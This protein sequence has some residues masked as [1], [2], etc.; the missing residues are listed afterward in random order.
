MDDISCSRGRPAEKRSFPDLSL[1][2]WYSGI[3]KRLFDI[4]FASVLIVLAALPML[5]AAIAI[6]IEGGGKVLFRQIRVGAGLKPFVC[7]K[8]RTMKHDAPHDCA[9]AK[10]EHPERYITRVGAALRRMSI[11]ELPQLF[12]VLRGDMSLVGPRPVIPAECGLVSLRE[13]LGVYSISPGITGLAQVRG[14]DCLSDRRKAA[15]D[16]QYLEHMSFFFDLKLLCC[17]VISVLTCRGIH[18]GR[19]GK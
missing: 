8:F 7:Y 11:D 2:H 1:S 10:L 12:N 5:A 6:K 3:P 15:F 16:S 9:T 19:V 14:R 18:E 13:C 4:V 17:T